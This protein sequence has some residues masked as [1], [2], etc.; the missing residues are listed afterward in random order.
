MTRKNKH[1][2]D[3]IFPFS[4]LFVFI[5]SALIVLVIA[6]SF[7]RKTTDAMQ[8]K[9]ESRIALSYITTKIR[10][11]DDRGQVEIVRLEGR[12]CLRL[13]SEV[14]G[15]LCYTYIY[16]YDGQLKELFIMDGVDFALK[17]GAD[18][19]AIHELTMTARTDQLFEFTTTDQTGTRYS[20]LVA[21]RSAP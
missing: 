18:I 15:T 1:I 6:A 20:T 7:Y 5:A 9:D 13:P 3:F 14:D 17:D 10:Q 4:L 2:I 16:A 21:E 11:N 8:Q 19:M 12:D